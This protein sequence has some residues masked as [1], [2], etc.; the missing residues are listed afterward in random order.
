MPSEAELVKSW[1]RLCHDPRT[2]AEQLENAA[3]WES[4]N[5]A[6]EY[7]IRL[8]VA[9][10]RSSP[11]ELLAKLAMINWLPI[12]IAVA[13]H[14]NI[15]ETTAGM[16]LRKQFRELR[17]A[18]AGNHKVPIFVMDKL[19]RDFTDIR[20]RLSRNPAIP[21]KIQLRLAK[22]KDSKI[23][24][25]LTQ[26]R[27]LHIKILERLSKDQIPDIRAGVAGH[28]NIPLAALIQMASDK[29]DLVRGV[30]LDRAMEEYQNEVELF[31]ALA[32]A[33]KGETASKAK[34]HLAFLELK[35]KS[36]DQTPENA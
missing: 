25:A 19:S 6:H 16:L 3:Y 30:I 35:A 15:S 14:Q 17:R 21:P 34:E 8:A 18:L 24:L 12:Q 13:G 33:G 29:S 9:K 22:E 23:R 7:Q 20:I 36:K 5:R 26:N 32:K 10:H 4:I 28:P 11:T 27:K 2:S 31:R 1:L